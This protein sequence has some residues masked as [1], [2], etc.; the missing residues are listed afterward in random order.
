MKLS[1]PLHPTAVHPL[2]GEPLRALY[3]DRHGRPRFPVMGGAPDDPP[4]N[5]P[6]NDPA[7]P[8][9]DPPNNPPADPPADPGFPKDTPLSEMTVEQREAYW[10]HQ[11]RKHESTWKGIVGD[12]TV[13]DVKNDLS[14]IE[15]IRQEQLTPAEKAIEEAERRGRESAAAESNTRA[16]K[17]ILR[18]N[19][20]AQGITDTDDDAELT[21]LVDSIDVG[22]FIVDGDVDTDKLSR[23]A[24]RFSTADTADTGRR[25]DF[26]AGRR[27]DPERTRG[28][29]GKAEAQKRF[30]K[31][32]D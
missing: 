18:A 28:A 21:E 17:A 6:P 12:R 27:R 15:R 14:E 10:K 9:A 2:T 29:G 32:T 19:L 22:R 30:K 25:R 24:K 5:D 8:P 3:V 13:D 7:D 20:Q 16:A 11:S 4:P 23:F 26:G 1:L 31:T